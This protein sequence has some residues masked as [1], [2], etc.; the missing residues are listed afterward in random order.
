MKVDIDNLRLELDDLQ[1]LLRMKTT[2][3]LEMREV[4]KKRMAD[5]RKI[6]DAQ[7]REAEDEDQE[8]IRK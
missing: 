7:K 4:I 5:I 2:K 1:A 3:N 6:L 8:R